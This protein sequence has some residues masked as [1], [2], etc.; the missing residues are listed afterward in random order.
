MNIK[1]IARMRSSFPSKYG[2][3]RQSGLVADL[4]STIVFEPEFR[5]ADALRGIESYSHLWLIW[6]FSENERDTWSPTVRPPRLGGN[7]RMG[8]FATRSTFRPNALALSSVQFESLEKTTNNGTVIHVLGADLM[9]G[10]PIYD[11]KPYLSFTD[12]HPDARNGFAD[13]VQSH[14]LHVHLPPK[15]AA[16]FRDRDL[17][18]LLK[19]LSQDPRPG[20][21]HDPERIYGFPFAGYE[22]RFR[23]S[24]NE[25]EV[26]DVTTHS[27]KS[28]APVQPT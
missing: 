14:A 26:V 28:S 19:I 10:T 16:M 17:H 5:N 22:I 25:L 9:D 7:V 3:P 8:V 1:V 6:G 18:S 21:Q 4:H 13:A 24:E 20:Y 11:I 2:I 23:V 15:F 27:Q 12:S